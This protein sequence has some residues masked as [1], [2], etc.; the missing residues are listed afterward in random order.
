[1]TREERTV[2]RDASWF[3]GRVDKMRKLFVDRN[4]EDIAKTILMLSEKLD[5]KR[6]RE[7]TLRAARNWA[8]SDVNSR[9][10][11]PKKP[12]ETTT[13]LEWFDAL[14]KGGAGLWRKTE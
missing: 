2:R 6:Q 7:R 9:A 11:R 8:A 3:Q 12:A 13:Q 4:D 10:P 1:M 5:P 14:M